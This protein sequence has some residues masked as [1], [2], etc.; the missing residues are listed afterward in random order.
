MFKSLAFLAAIIGL[1]FSACINKKCLENLEQARMMPKDTTLMYYWCRLKPNGTIDEK[2]GV[3]FAPSG[4]IYFDSY[5]N[6]K[7]TYN[8]V[9][10][11][12]D[13]SNKKYT[14]ISCANTNR[15]Y[16]QDQSYRIVKDTLYLGQE[17][18]LRKIKYTDIPF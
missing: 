15:T 6:I 7:K 13:S 18:Y 2:D 16:K 10:Y 5:Q 1:I 3:G 9:W 12:L 17:K 11:N 8:G 4:Y 14:M